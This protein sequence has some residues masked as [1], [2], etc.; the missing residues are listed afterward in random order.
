[1][2]PKYRLFV[3]VLLLSLALDQSTKIAVRRTL[4]PDDRAKQA[5]RTTYRPGLDPW[6]QLSTRQIRVVEGFFDV[7]YSENTGVAFGLGKKVPWGVWVGVGV[8]AL[9]L[10]ITFLRQARNGQHKLVLSLALVGSGAI[11]NIVD[12]ARFGYV[13]DFVVWRWHEHTWPTFNVADAALVVGVIL[14]F[15]TMGKKPDESAGD[16]SGEAAPARRGRKGKAR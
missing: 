14:M 1:V 4:A 11:G 10:I 2:S 6:C 3:I 16:E 5:Y 8:L 12:R 9:G 7:C 13:T 15:L